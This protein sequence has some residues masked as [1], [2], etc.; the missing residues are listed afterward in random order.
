M[1]KELQLFLDALRFLTRFPVPPVAVFN[2]KE[3]SRMMRY[4][5]VVGWII[6]L[7]TGVVWLVGS[8]LISV[9]V[10]LLLSIIVGI[11]ATGAFHE[12]GFADS[13]DGFGGGWTK[14]RILEIMKDSRLGTYGVT[15]LIG[16]LSLK[17]SLLLHILREEE[18]PILIILTLVNAHTISRFMA[19]TFLFTHSYSRDSSDSKVSAVAQ[20]PLLSDL[21]VAGIF[22]L[23]PLV[24]WVIF[25]ENFWLLLL[26]P[27]LYSVKVLMGRY[28]VRWIGGYTG[29]CLGATQQVCEICFYLFIA[30][31]WKFI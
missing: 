5:P 3:Q 23:V 10:G 19:S 4:F 7:L 28:F 16:I 17:F 31:L 2:E 25:D 26:L 15:G 20:K 24:S 30:V 6:G 8:F 21:L 29:D 22:M 14:T 9:P 11:L 1:K 18:E 13:C 12:D 27:F